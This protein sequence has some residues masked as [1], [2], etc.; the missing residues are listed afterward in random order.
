M[1][2]VMARLKAHTHA[3]HMQLE[4]NRYAV[5]I[6]S[7]TLTRQAYGEFLLKF[8]RFYTPLEPRLLA[9]G[10]LIPLG[11]D[12]AER[13]KLPA[14]TRDLHALGIDP[15]AHPVCPA[16]PAL[17]NLAAVLGVLYVV[18]GSTLGGQVIHRQLRA[19]FGEQAPAVTHFFSGYGP[20]TGPR[21][22]QFGAAVNA[23]VTPALEPITLEAA[24]ETFALF[25][26][27]VN[28]PQAE[29]TPV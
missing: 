13:Q 22:K 2:T 12:Y 10:E 26:D 4:Q 11:L 7:Q 5:A 27:W 20:L 18:E 28:A 3:A 6:E 23:R 21:W 9:C 17:P 16:T 15:E 29:L 8:H 24:R 19:L 1:D 25:A 14:L